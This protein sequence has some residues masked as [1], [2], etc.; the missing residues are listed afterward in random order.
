MKLIRILILGAT[1]V[2]GLAFTTPVQARDHDHDHDRNWRDNSDW[3]YHHHHHYR[4]GVIVEESTPTYGY[5]NGN[6]V[7]VA[8][9][10]H[11]HHSYHH[12]Y[13]YDHR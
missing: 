8:F 6:G 13:Y 1:A 5:V 9:G 11:V 3:H 12:R 2:A 4:N 10:G 7:S